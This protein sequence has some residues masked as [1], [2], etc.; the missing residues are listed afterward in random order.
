MLTQ[1]VWVSESES[2]HVLFCVDLLVKVASLSILNHLEILVVKL[3]SFEVNNC[4]PLSFIFLF[5]G[6]LQLL[7]QPLEDIGLVVTELLDLFAR[8][9]RVT[10]AHSLRKHLSFHSFADQ[11][12]L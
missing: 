4:S 2:V 9:S 3:A 5:Q 1:S 8:F 6:L 10:V 7:K 11:S 12:K